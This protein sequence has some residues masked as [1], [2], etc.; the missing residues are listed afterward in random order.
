[1][2]NVE[3]EHVAVSWQPELS[4]KLPDRI[5]TGTAAYD[6][7]TD[8][9][10]EPEGAACSTTRRIVVVSPRPAALNELVGALTERCY[11]VLLFHRTD[12]PVLKLLQAD[13]WI[14]DLSSRGLEAPL[15]RKDEPVLTL[16]QR[17]TAPAAGEAAMVWPGELAGSLARIDAAL[18]QPLPQQARRAVP[19]IAANAIDS[20]DK[21][22]F[23]DVTLDRKRMTVQRRGSR[24]ELTKTEFELLAAL[25]EAGGGVL[26]RQELL[27]RVWGEQYFGGS[28]T[29]DV[30]IKSLRQ[31]LG[32]DPRKQHIIATVRGVG[33]RLAD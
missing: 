8:R 7:G 21:L 32:D 22:S 30:H 16:V 33:Y 24:V 27:D 1:M 25:L 19:A 4:R 18:E 12:D 23:R 26:S 10:S 14:V 28:N 2:Q 20:G 3:T 9:L 29:V 5:V 6:S 31:K 17:G 13:L 15:A 11:D